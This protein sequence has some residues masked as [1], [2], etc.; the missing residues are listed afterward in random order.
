MTKQTRTNA[1]LGVAL[2]A[3]ATMVFAAASAARLAAQ[4]S[5]ITLT[6]KYT[7]KGDV[8]ATHRLWIWLFDTPD[9]GPGAMPFDER[10]LEKNGDS[11]TFKGVTV[12]NVYVAV[13]YD[14]QGGFMGQ[15]PPPSGSP[16]TVH[17]AEAAGAP[18]PITPGEKGAVT[19]TFNETVR[20][21]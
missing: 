3:G 20:M 19:I 11:I 6:V 18:A 8:D 7:G 10:S 15:A 14:E 1:L 2:I 4:S 16:V 9:I 13:A 21:P 12:K 17:G 5:D